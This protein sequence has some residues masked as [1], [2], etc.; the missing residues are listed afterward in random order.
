MPRNVPAQRQ[1]LKRSRMNV[2]RQGDVFMQDGAPSHNARCVKQVRRCHFGDDR[3]INSL[4]SQI[5]RLESYQLLAV[6]IPQVHGLL[7]SH[8]I[9]IRP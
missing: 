6:G 3:I 9:S 7:G 5:P 4:T 1:A 2:S 8:P